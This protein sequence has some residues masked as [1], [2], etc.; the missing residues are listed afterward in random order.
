MT[1][2]VNKVKVAERIA[3]EVRADAS[4]EKKRPEFIKRLK[5]E[6]NCTDKLARSYWQM[7]KYEADGKGTRY[8]HHNKKKPAA[9]V[10]E[11]G[12]AAVAGTATGSADSA[13][14]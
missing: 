1:D 4:I 14:A 9:P 7:F 5:A 10:A 6:T 11:V 2:K 8:K 12:D 13:A 3:A